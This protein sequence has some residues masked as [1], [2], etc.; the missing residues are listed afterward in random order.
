MRDNEGLVLEY[1]DG[2]E[3]PGNLLMVSIMCLKRWG[4]RSGRSISGR[5]PGHLQELIKKKTLTEEESKEISE[6]FLMSRERVS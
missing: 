5:V 2:R 4:Q 3:T 6:Y 1:S